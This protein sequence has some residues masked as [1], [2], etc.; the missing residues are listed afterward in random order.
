[1]ALLEP[2][3]RPFASAMSRLT[4]CNPFLP[5][6]ID[7]ERQALGDAFIQ[8]DADWNVRID[9]AG[10]RRSARRKFQPSRNDEK[11]DGEKRW[12]QVRPVL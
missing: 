9:S 5:E 10:L 7:L 4:Y 11:T 1:M 3:E 6:R 8:V 12:F 2:A